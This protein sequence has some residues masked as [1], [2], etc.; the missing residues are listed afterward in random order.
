MLLHGE[1]NSVF[2]N[3]VSALAHDFEFSL[4]A[5]LVAASPT[6]FFGYSQGWYYSGTRW[7]EQYDRS[8]GAPLGPAK[9]GTGEANMTWTREFESGT[10][11]ELDILH[12][13]STI[14]WTS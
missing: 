7:H 14:R 8:L 3:N 5:F 13:M 6:A 10:S 11:V 1:V 4:A 12:H 9:R 2:A